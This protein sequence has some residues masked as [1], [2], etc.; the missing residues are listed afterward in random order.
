MVINKTKYGI[1]RHVHPPS[2]QT[3]VSKCG[4]CETNCHIERLTHSFVFD[5][6]CGE[7]TSSFYLLLYKMSVVR[8]RARVVKTGFTISIFFAARLSRWN[9]SAVESTGRLLRSEKDFYPT[10]TCACCCLPLPLH[11]SSLS[12][13]VRQCKARYDSLLIRSY[14]N[15]IECQMLRIK[16]NE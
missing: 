9:C 1:H 10:P 6:F 2:C 3:C 15:K 11:T 7:P 5:S 4:K 14:F 8:K 12:S 16:I 13:T